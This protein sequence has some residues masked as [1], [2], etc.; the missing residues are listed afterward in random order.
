MA[1]GVDVRFIIEKNKRHSQ[2]RLMGL[3]KAEGSQGRSKA[4]KEEKAGRKSLIIIRNGYG[5]IRIR[6]L[7]N[8][9][10]QEMTRE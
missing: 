1:G 7:V 9:T 3:C 8:S 2:E 5:G 10:D 6:F 4:G